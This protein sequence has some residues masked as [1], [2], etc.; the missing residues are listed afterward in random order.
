MPLASSF[1]LG[2]LLGS[3]LGSCTTTPSLD[4]GEEAS[5]SL[6]GLSRVS[7]FAGAGTGAG[8]GVDIGVRE[9]WNNLATLVV[10]VP[11]VNGAT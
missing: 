3:E 7:L 2:V 1:S 9:V 5:L 6:V 4:G 8:V 11:V 10:R